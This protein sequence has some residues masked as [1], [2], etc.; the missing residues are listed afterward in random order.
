MFARQLTGFL[1][2]SLQSSTYALKCVHTG[3]IEDD[4][5]V[6]ALNSNG[7]LTGIL[8]HN[9]YTITADGTIP[10]PL[11]RTM[12]VPP[13]GSQEGDEF[14]HRVATAG[15]WLAVSAKYRHPSTN[16][17]WNGAVY[18]YK[19]QGGFPPKA[20]FVGSAHGVWTPGVYG[21]Q[22]GQSLS[23]TEEGRLV[24]GTQVGVVAVYNVDS[25]NGLRLV[26]E[27]KPFGNS[28]SDHDAAFGWS[29]AASGDFVAVSAKWDGQQGDQAGAVYLYHVDSNGTVTEIKKLVYGGVQAQFGWSVAL[30]AQEGLLVVSCGYLYGK[31]LVYRLG[32]SAPFTPTLVHEI[33][34]PGKFTNFGFSVSISGSRIAVGAPATSGPPVA[35]SPPRVHIYEVSAANVSEVARLESD[36]L[37]GDAHASY[38][39]YSIAI[40]D[41]IAV[42][43]A[44]TTH[45]TQSV[46]VFKCQE[47]ALT[48]S[49]VM[50]VLV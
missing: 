11:A 32:Q 47:A 14:G 49:T 38:L 48:A 2:V 27:L 19:L 15:H 29:V 46:L 41:D 8:G 34:A 9:L 5:R 26:T 31:V 16:S 12:L 21:T 4:T 28:N 7:G 45:G 30:D 40:H 43:A 22:L 23:V 35:Q 18:A 20:T 33:K 3:T 50:D 39:G 10:R 44:P 36:S 6:V 37:D 17:S 1:A 42:A 13:D 25:V 24:A